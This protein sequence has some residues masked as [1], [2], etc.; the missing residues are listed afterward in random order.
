MQLTHKLDKTI[1]HTFDYTIATEIEQAI[2]AIGRTWFAALWD[3]DIDP[4]G[5]KPLFKYNGR[6]SE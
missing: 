5:R 2:D 6:S 3:W 4:I 1:T